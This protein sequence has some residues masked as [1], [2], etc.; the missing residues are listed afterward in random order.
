MTGVTIPASLHASMVKTFQ[1]EY[2]DEFGSLS[3]VQQYALTDLVDKYARDIRFWKTRIPNLSDRKRPTMREIC[4]HAITTNA[5]SNMKK[6]IAERNL[7]ALVREQL[8]NVY[9]LEYD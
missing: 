2:E 4:A 7:E 5:V 1:H 6:L 3:K 9:E 8:T